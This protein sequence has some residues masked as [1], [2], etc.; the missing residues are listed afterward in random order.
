MLEGEIS[1]FLGGSEISREGKS[2]LVKYPLVLNATHVFY[3]WVAPILFLRIN[4]VRIYFK[5]RVQ[6]INLAIICDL[7]VFMS[8][9]T[10]SILYLIDIH[11]DK[12]DRNN[13][14]EEK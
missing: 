2:Y 14:K 5:W 1:I 12:K 13:K 8:I 7:I 9:L 3:T 6:K 11:P 4:S 10:V